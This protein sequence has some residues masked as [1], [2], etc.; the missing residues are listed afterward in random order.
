LLRIRF[1]QFIIAVISAVLLGLFVTIYVLHSTLVDIEDSLPITVTEQERDLA[2]LYQ[3]FS[4]LAGAISI[5]KNIPSKQ[6]L[7]E[8]RALAQTVNKR[9][10]QIRNTY[11]FDNL[12]GASAIHAI[13]SPAIFDIE[14]WLR[15]GVY[16][17]APGSRVVLNLIDRRADIALKKFA[18]LLSQARE[19]ATGIYRQQGKR[20]Q[21]LRRTVNLLLGFMSAMIIALIVLYSAIKRPSGRLSTRRTPRNGRAGPRANFWPI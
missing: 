4:G 17:F 14:R 16:D 8:A 9:L 15:A 5:A 3:G 2:L 19:T 1:S 7:D 10:K 20:I 6:R 11:N 13:V 18:R 21:Q 12:I